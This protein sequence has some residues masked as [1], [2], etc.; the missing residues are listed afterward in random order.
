MLEIEKIKIFIEKH[1]EELAFEIYSSGGFLK[2]VTCEIDYTDRKNPSLSVYGVEIEETV[3]LF[4]ISET[5]FKI[6]TKKQLETSIQ[7][8]RKQLNETVCHHW[9]IHTL[10]NGI[11][12]F[13]LSMLSL[14][15][16]LKA[17]EIYQKYA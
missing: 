15:D 3:K 1:N 2:D 14:D 6:P 11:E 13:V 4:S 7:N 16:Y 10:K 5:C 12:Q 8:S 17:L 9:C